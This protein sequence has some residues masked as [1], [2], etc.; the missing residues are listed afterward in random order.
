MDENTLLPL[1]LLCVLQYFVELNDPHSAV[2]C[3]TTTFYF[4]YSFYLTDEC[5]LT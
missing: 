5:L 1:W 4:F 2:L 3:V